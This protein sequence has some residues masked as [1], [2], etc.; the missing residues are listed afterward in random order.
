M[1]LLY[2]GFRYHT[3]QVPIMKGWSQRGDEVY[4]F[5]QFEGV[6]EVHDYVNFSLMK[7]TKGTLRRNALLDRD[8]PA[9]VA[10]SKKIRA[11]MPDLWDVYKKIRAIRPDVVII[12]EYSKPNSVVVLAC[13]LLGIKNVVMYVQ[14][15]LYG[16]GEKLNRGQKLFRS[17][18]FPSACFTPV[19]YRGKLRSHDM[20]APYPSRPGWFVPLVCEERTEPEREY[21]R[22]GI[23]HILDVGKYRD[24]KNHFFLVDAIAAME[25]KENIHVTIIGQL[26][27]DA[28]RDYY[29][30]LKAYVNEKQ[31]VDVIELRGNIP[32]Y[33]MQELYRKQDVLALASTLETAGMVILEAM[34]MGLCVVS[35]INCGLASYLEE[36]D[37]GFTFGLDQPERLSVILDDLAVNPEKI[38]TAG[39]ASRK[40]VR[41]QYGFENYVNC[42]GALLKAEYGFEGIK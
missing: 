16:K 10:E 9:D 17:L 22:N 4:Y 12:R 8:Y 23:V 41:E 38:A 6:S 28:E 27:N 5:A 37:C 13:R 40:A 2:V 19:L 15:P 20:P 7:P 18:C 24:Y 42:M 36:N 39:I 3:N 32:F 31:L 34:A 1:K 21:C 33:E 35:S 25:H 29:E 26:S 14:T 30:K 11:F